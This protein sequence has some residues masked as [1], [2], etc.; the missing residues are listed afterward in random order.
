MLQSSSPVRA[1][2]RTSPLKSPTTLR[3]G[4]GPPSLRALSRSRRRAQIGQLELR[5]LAE[6]AQHARA[7]DRVAAG[8]LG[9]AALRQPDR[10]QVAVDLG[11]ERLELAELLEVLGGRVEL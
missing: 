4:E 9:T 3:T 5:L 6:L 1:Q 11:V 10:Q 7:V 8:G 2:A